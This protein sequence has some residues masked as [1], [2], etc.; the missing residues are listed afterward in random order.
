MTSGT[1]IQ[2]VELRDGG[3]DGIWNTG[4]YH[5]WGAVKVYTFDVDAQN[6]PFELSFDIRITDTNGAVLQA[7]ELVTAW[8]DGAEYDFGSNF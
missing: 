2:S 5:D 7:N 6:R 4:V 1:T 3:N 8:T